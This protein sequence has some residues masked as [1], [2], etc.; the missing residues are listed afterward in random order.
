L[1]NMYG[2]MHDQSRYCSEEIYV[3]QFCANIYDMIKT[4]YGP[5]RPIE[6]LGAIKA[7]KF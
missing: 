7:F 5:F 2:T 6:L 1:V 4:N 3:A